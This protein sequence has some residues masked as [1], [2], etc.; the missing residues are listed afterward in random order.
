MPRRG[1][2]YNA[3][4][5]VRLNAE[6]VDLLMNADEQPVRLT[7]K[8]GL[9]G[10][11]Y[12][13]GWSGTRFWV[14]HR[15]SRNASSSAPDVVDY[16]KTLDLNSTAYVTA[17]GMTQV[18]SPPFPLYYTSMRADN[19]TRPAVPTTSTSSSGT[20]SDSISESLS[21]VVVTSSTS[22]ES[23]SSG[24]SSSSGSLSDPVSASLSTG[25]VMTAAS[26]DNT[27]DSGNDSSSSNS[28]ISSSSSGSKS[29]SHTDSTSS[30][31]IA[32]TTLTLAL[33]VLI[34]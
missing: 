8:A 12:L 21:T 31:T 6:G 20:S 32:L 19:W 14:S 2:D 25:V 15:L 33:M 3:R 17:S 9:Q 23:S 11:Y 22:V 4:P 27:N 30:L 10:T 18:T 1:G 5:D 13:V 29:D 34:A 16:L 28:S 7:L 26:V 24:G